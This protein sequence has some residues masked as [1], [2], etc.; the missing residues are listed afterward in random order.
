M[1]AE[2]NGKGFSE[3]QNDGIGLKN[4]YSRVNYLK[5]KINIDSGKSGTTIMIQIP[6]Y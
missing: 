4:I 2:D 3:K 5:G 6:Y 1:M